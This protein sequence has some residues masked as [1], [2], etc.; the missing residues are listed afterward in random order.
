MIKVSV[1]FGLAVLMVGCATLPPV[2]EFAKVP[3]QHGGK[4]TSGYV[5]MANSTNDERLACEYN[6]CIAS[7]ILNTD[8]N[9][10]PAKKNHEA[11]IKPYKN[12]FGKLIDAN[13]RYIKKCPHSNITT[14]PF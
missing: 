11:Y 10:L 1:G 4:K 12:D 5:N 14:Y 8:K 7:E 2:P 9:C 13:E 3:S 6:Y